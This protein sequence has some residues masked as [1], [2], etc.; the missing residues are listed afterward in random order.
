MTAA[1]LS[2]VPPNPALWRYVWKLL[3]LRVVILVSE[4]RRARLRRK[5]GM[6]LLGLLAVAGLVFAFRAEL[7]AAQVPA[8]SAAGA[9]H[10]QYPA[11]AGKHANAGDHRRLLWRSCSPA[12]AVL[13]QA[14]YLAGD[15]DFL[16]SAPV[17]IRAIF[18]TKLLQAILP[19]FSLI[20]LFGLPV[21]FGLGASGGYNVS[22]LPP[23]ADR[24]GAGGAGH[25]RPV[26]PA[27]DGGGAHL[28]CPARG[29]SPGLRRG[30]PLLHLLA[31]RSS[32]PAMP[33]SRRTRR[34]RC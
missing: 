17:P 18:I 8:L 33:T 16:L 2:H 22:V 34:R 3:R 27:G 12:S 13:L 7:A 19:N 30:D 6:I 1:T 10:G 32:L 5:I 24:A 11:A 14:L 26:Q 21:L 20:L 31:V 9:V 29:R 23:G 15:M 28:P 25:R 4:F